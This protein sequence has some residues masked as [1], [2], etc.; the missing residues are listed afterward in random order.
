[1][2]GFLDRGQHAVGLSRKRTNRLR[3]ALD[4]FELTTSRCEN[5]P[6]GVK[7]V[8]QWSVVDFVWSSRCGKSPST[9]S[10]ASGVCKK[11]QQAHDAN[12]E[13]E[14]AK[15]NSNRQI[16]R[17]SW[18]NKLHQRRK[19]KFPY[20]LR[21][22]HD[23]QTT[24]RSQQQKQIAISHDFIKWKFPFIKVSARVGAEPSRKREKIILYLIAFTRI[25][26]DGKG[27]Y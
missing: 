3:T 4:C 11:R 24:K 12:S 14:I 16:T 19:S 17:L 18:V 2:K 15:A 20:T 25:D 26:D 21:Y 13:L 5:P 10:H 9:C 8:C 22:S 6:I 7:K 27:N 23:S 1:M